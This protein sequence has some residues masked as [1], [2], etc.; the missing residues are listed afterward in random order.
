MTLMIFGIATLVVVFVYLIAKIAFHKSIETQ[1]KLLERSEH[2]NQRKTRYFC[3]LLKIE[4]P[5]HTGEL[6]LARGEVLLDKWDAAHKK[7]DWNFFTRTVN[8]IKRGKPVLFGGY[9]SSLDELNALKQV[10]GPF[11]KSL[12]D[13]FQNFLLEQTVSNYYKIQEMVESSEKKLE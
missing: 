8:G 9:K 1:I 13:E 4:F 2:N 6:D 10:V 5:L 7:V 12:S 3:E 11:G